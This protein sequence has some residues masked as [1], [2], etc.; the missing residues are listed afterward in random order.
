MVMVDDCYSR[1]VEALGRTWR[2]WGG[3][4]GSLTEAQWSTGT[5]CSGWDVACL[6]A[7]HSRVPWRWSV[8]PPRQ[9]ES[10]SGSPLTAVEV[11]R[12]YN[13]PG[14]VASTAAPAVASAA[15]TEAAQH[16]PAE[17]VERFTVLGPTVI[18]QLRTADPDYVM[19]Q[20]AVDAGMTLREVLRIV[21]MEATVHLLDVQ[22]ALNLDPAVPDAALA[23]TSRLLAEVAPAVELIEAATGRSTES[24][25]P[26]VR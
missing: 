26:V 9:P 24:P 23:E 11:L 14:G 15:V 6:Y 21:L 7:H 17:F 1:R 2:A 4:G 18:D 13:S 10:P 20:P 3:I 19:A 25:F 22:R 8:W 16:A 5:R 12:S